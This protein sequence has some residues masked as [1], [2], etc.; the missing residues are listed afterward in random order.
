MLRTI[1]MFCGAGG[2]SF[3]ARN[4]KAQIVA[5][6]DIW[7]PAIKTYK[8]NFPEAEMF[9]ED[10]RL[11][12]PEKIKRQIGKIDLLLAS[13]ECTNHSVAKG[14]KDRCEESKR[15]VFEVIRFAKAFRPRYMVI[16]NVIQM[17]SWIEHP[18]VVKE[19]WNLDYF[20][21]EVKLN[22]EDFG[23]PQSRK[24][25]FLLCTNLKYKEPSSPGKTHSQPTAAKVIIDRSDKYRFSL[26]FSDKRAT[27]TL[28]RAERAIQALG[29][30]EEF[31]LVYY[32]TDGAGGWQSLE[33]PLRTITTIDRF[34]YVKPT[35]NGH[36][37]RMLQ[38]EELKLAMG[39][40]MN[41]DFGSGTTR[42]DKIKLL[43][44]GV[45]PPV[46]EAIVNNLKN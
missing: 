5:G 37:M 35:N 45:C 12:D 8:A 16:E 46:M 15:T 42:R 34:A 11:L 1:D 32:G 30:K 10:I 19:L 14:A 27:A 9:H 29:K 44:N 2:S 22:S 26:L 36:I 31:L 23:V 3:G 28:E 18:T 33:K 24:R 40:D 4:A 43:G 41:F 6:F 25:L 39:F 7:G 21:K 38:P 13:P 20:V 17:G